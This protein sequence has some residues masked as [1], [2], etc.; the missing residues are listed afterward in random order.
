M[1]LTLREV[2]DLLEGHLKSVVLARHLSGLSE[3]DPV[4]QSL[5]DECIDIRVV[6]DYLKL[7]DFCGIGLLPVDYDDF[8]SMLSVDH[9]DFFSSYN[10]LAQRILQNAAVLNVQEGTS[11]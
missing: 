5:T 11:P 4:A 3:S 9:D 2:I 1:T 6:L 10:V 8:L 7:L